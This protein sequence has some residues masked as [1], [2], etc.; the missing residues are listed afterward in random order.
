[1]KKF[2]ALF[3]FTMMITFASSPFAEHKVFWEVPKSYIVKD[4]EPH[5][6]PVKATLVANTKV[7]LYDKPEEKGA[8]VIGTVQEGETVERISCIVYTNP[9]LHPVKIL[10]TFDVLSSADGE[11]TF[12]LQEGEYLYLVMYLGEGS[13]LGLYQ[14]KEAWWLDM[15]SIKNFWGKADMPTAWGEYEGSPTNQGL[16]VNTWDCIKKADGTAGWTLSQKD[17]EFLDNFDIVGSPF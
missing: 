7:D 3:I 8:N 2:F 15:M 16:S 17:G 13:V 14:G 6:S 5:E 11:E 4:R 1:M 10:R 9:A 12:T